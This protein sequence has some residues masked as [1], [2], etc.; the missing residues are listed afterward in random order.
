MNPEEIL[1][2]DS[3]KSRI[4]RSLQMNPEESSDGIRKKIQMD[5]EE[6][7]YVHSEESLQMDSEKKP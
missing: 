3:I 2:M 6:S 5:Y 7:H 4:L 1:Q